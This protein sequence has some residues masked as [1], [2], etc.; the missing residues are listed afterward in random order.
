VR[1]RT[2]CKSVAAASR[3]R[4]LRWAAPLLALLLLLAP[5]VAGAQNLDGRATTYL[6]G[7]ATPT[8]GGAATYLPFYELVE[9]HGRRLGVDGLS[10]HSSFWG[11][12]DTVD[13]QDR[14]RATGDVSAL[15][16]NYR[17]PEEGRLKFLRG[18]E[19]TAGRQFVALGP[20]ILEQVDGGKLHYLHSSGLEVGFFGGAPTGTRIAFQPWPVDEDRYSYGYS[21]LLGG[22]IGYLDLGN[23]AAGASFVHRS[24]HGR[25]AD[26]D[27]GID[28]S[29]SPLALLDVSGSATMSLE[30]LRPREVKGSIGLR[31]IRCL[32]FNL[33]YRY[34]SPDLLVPRTSIFAVFS[35]ETF[36]EAG[37]DA[38]W[39]PTRAVSVDAGYGLRL[40]SAAEDL[41]T[42]VETHNRASLRGQLRF[43]E[44]LAGR[45]VAEAERVE[46]PQNAATRVRLATAVPFHLARRAISA[47]V[48]LDLYVLDHT[49][50][51]TTLSFTGGGYLEVGLT[52]GL[53][54]MAGG[55]ASTTTL[56]QNA[57]TFLVRLTW[58]FQ[59]PQADGAVEVRRGRMQ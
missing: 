21:W 1:T 12:V 9:L 39:Q 20:T 51:D 27:L 59:S 41:R 54:L 55:S 17:A 40:Y 44:A 31:P 13:I 8:S 29:Y 10:L 14:Y 16:L 32:T 33:G 5:T 15:Y 52:D 35:E 4:P 22:R 23:L 6:R 57:G 7:F 28:L 19:L 56:L 26:N 48:D 18:L 46:A 34:S 2:S 24:Y 58:D 47:I 38:R 50:R 3:G 43:G 42:G 53:R 45:V 25:I 36:Q 37:I 49:I 30:A 11:L